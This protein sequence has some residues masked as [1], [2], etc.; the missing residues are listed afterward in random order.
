MSPGGGGNP[1]GGGDKPP[2]Q[3]VFTGHDVV[4]VLESARLANIKLT[5]E[6]FDTEATVVISAYK[7]NS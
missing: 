3:H 2:G 7:E 4:R 6:G 1:P 5:S